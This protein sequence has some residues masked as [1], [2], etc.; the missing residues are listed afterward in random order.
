[1]TA[2]KKNGRKDNAAPVIDPD[3]AFWSL[4]RGEKLVE[5]LS[6]GTLSIAYAKKSQQFAKEMNKRASG[7]A[8][9][10][11]AASALLC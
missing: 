7:K 11:T 4:V 10:P 1:M 9:S 6:G 3:T 5:V 8:E 2:T